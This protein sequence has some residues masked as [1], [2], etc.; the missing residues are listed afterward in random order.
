MAG[1]QNSAAD[2]VVDDKPVI[3]QTHAAIL[4][5]NGYSTESFTQSI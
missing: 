4:Q 5:I 2:F 1:M 3:A